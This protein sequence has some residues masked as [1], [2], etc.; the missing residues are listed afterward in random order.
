MRE[1]GR[2]IGT[3]DRQT[4][5]QTHRDRETDR[6]TYR[7]RETARQS[8]RVADQTSLLRSGGGLGL[9]PAH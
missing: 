2:L 6:E 1:K 7:Q 8:E 3:R 5:R 4:E 9:I